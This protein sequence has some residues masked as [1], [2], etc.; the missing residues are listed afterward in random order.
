[1]GRPRNEDAKRSVLTMRVSD[2]VRSRLLL[3]AEGN[4]RSLSGEIEY[5]LE[6]SFGHG[7]AA[8]QQ[9]Q[10]F[11]N[12]LGARIGDIEA[13]YG[14]SWLCDPKAWAAVKDATLREVDSHAPPADDWNDIS[15]AT[16]TLREEIQ[17]AEYIIN[18]IR[19]LGMVPESG[20]PTAPT[21][22][23]SHHD[24]DFILARFHRLSL[25]Q[26]R[27][28]QAQ[29]QLEIAVAHQSGAIPPQ[30]CD[31]SEYPDSGGQEK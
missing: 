31:A 9:T 16:R 25:Q 30:R 21:S 18:E 24:V 3:A 17:T 13:R 19:E 7:A 27:I 10:A 2:E 1:M 26:A 20:E 11:L 15:S 22:P 23:V 5:R 12:L 28:G 14:A 29:H 4:G 6:K 8:S